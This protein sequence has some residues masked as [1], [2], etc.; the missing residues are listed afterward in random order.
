LWYCDSP[1][2]TYATRHST[3]TCNKILVSIS[4]HRT[5][6]EAAKASTGMKLPPTD[7]GNVGATESL[8]QTLS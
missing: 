8:L 6:A 5:T 4:S 7:D 2:M 3:R 1:E